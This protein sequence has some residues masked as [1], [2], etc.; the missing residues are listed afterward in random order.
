MLLFRAFYFGECELPERFECV[1]H[2]P[3]NQ[4]G[5]TNDDTHFGTITSLGV[6]CHITAPPE[7]GEISTM[8]IVEAKILG[9]DLAQS[10]VMMQATRF[11][12]PFTRVG[13][14]A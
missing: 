2:S 3:F 8:S 13:E 10:V 5:A 6:R 12:R 11:V 4:A 1:V 14:W 9:V 7:I